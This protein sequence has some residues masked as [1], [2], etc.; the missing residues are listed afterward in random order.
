M[1]EKKIN[2][3]CGKKNYW[4]VD[5]EIDAYSDIQGLFYLYFRNYF[6]LCYC[7]PKNKTEN[8]ELVEYGK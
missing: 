4:Y 8:E 3:K 5:M 2:F 1:K 7:K 6:S